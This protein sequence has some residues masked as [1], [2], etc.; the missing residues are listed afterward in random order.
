MQYVNPAK[1][2]ENIS[3]GYFALDTNWRFTYINEKAQKLLRKTWDELIGQDIFVVLGEG[4]ESP[5]LPKYQEAVATGRPVEFEAFV[6]SDNSWVKVRAVPCPE[7][8][9]VFCHDITT[10]KYLRKLHETLNSIRKSSD[11]ITD[12]DHF[13]QVIIAALM[14][15]LDCH[16]AVGCKYEQN[17]WQIKYVCNKPPGIIGG[18]LPKS[19][20]PHLMESI[21]RRTPVVFKRGDIFESADSFVTHG[22][23]TGSTLV[24]PLFVQGECSLGC[25]FFNN[26][27][28]GFSEAQIEF[29]KRAIEFVEPLLT[30]V[31][32]EIQDRRHLATFRAILDQAPMGIALFDTSMRYTQ[33]NQWIADR[34]KTTP[35]ELIG[36]TVRE[37]ATE[38]LGYAP[39][40]QITGIY[41]QILKTGETYAVNAYLSLTSN[42]YSDW[43]LKRI[44][45]DGVPIGLLLTGIDVSKHVQLQSELEE[46]RRKL[47]QLVQ[48]RTSEFLRAN[49]RFYTAFNAS[50]SL[51][52]IHDREGKIVDINA[53]FE[54]GTGWSKA[55][56]IGR[57]MSEI[58][59]CSPEF[60]YEVRKGFRQEGRLKNRE[61]QFCTKDGQA[62]TGLF[63]AEGIVLDGKAHI[64]TLINDVTEIKLMEK[65]MQHLDR[66]NL[67]GQMAAG[68]S[69]EVRNPM[70]TV[71]G[72]LQMLMKKD[73]CLQ[74]QE[75]FELMI[76]ELD[77]A[78]SIIS[79][80]LSVARTRKSDCIETNINNII[81]AIE[82]LLTTDALAS[83]KY[84]VLE[85]GA[86]HNLRLDEKEIR[87][88]L[89]NLVRNGLEAMPRTGS[90]TIKTYEEKEQV[91][92]VV[93]DEG[94]GIP[95]HIITR[96]GTPF[97]TSKVNGTG[98]GLAVCYAIAGRH[99]AK[100]DV[101]TSAKGTT[102]Y[103]RF[104]KELV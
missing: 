84:V 57:T 14:E 34:L 63:S 21:F 2:L 50:P 67:V 65:E 94:E 76:S 54:K 98:L 80:F 70:T 31:V 58:N 100:I 95:T 64:L 42:Y 68:I 79:E 9:L 51:M 78:N 19:I 30:N 24:M 73:G 23:A 97:L 59:L 41:K 83:S 88:L 39:A 104:N 77:R 74:Y 36:R 5:F 93:Q 99:N 26:L 52:A 92:L 82:P 33:V 96:L 37:V 90:I 10:E 71:R 13:I 81:R 17:S 61:M 62:R 38:K 16:S 40:E 55:A 6:R 45:V 11:L 32:L 85:L 43:V 25:L 89:L 56:V 47:E 18:N 15:G 12:M 22:R 28:V 103:V 3:D 8:L 66:L 48:A 101:T 49:E 60:V 20:M 44:E 7:G 1:F 102:V 4:K 46:Y 27:T 86:V 75:Y 53:G 91:V 29:A 87:Q 35:D 69:H 72:F